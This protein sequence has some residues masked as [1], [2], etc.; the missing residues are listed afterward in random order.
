MERLKHEGKG[1]GKRE[2]KVYRR[3]NH[4][5]MRRAIT[6]FAP[7]MQFPRPAKVSN[8]CDTEQGLF[9]LEHPEPNIAVPQLCRAMGINDTE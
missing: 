4:G 8:P 9:H 7:F 5:S 3:P 1:Q 2:L 6:P